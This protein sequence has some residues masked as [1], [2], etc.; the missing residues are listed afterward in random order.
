MQTCANL[1][2]RTTPALPQAP[3]ELDDDAQDGGPDG[4]GGSAFPASSR[5]HVSMPQVRGLVI[6]GLVGG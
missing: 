6:M 2:V 5:A 1:L 4:R 3:D